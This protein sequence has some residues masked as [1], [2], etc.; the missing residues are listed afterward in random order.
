MNRFVKMRSS[1]Y[2]SVI[3]NNTFFHPNI[4]HVIEQ[5]IEEADCSITR[6]I[7]FTCNQLQTNEFEQ[8]YEI[9]AAIQ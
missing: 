4:R 8:K 7:F 1:S 6:S 2:C 3:S 5:R 9:L